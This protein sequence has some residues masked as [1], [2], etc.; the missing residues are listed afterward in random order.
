MNLWRFINPFVALL[1]RSPLHFLISSQLLVVSFKGIKSGKKYL[2]PVSYHQH[3][4]DYTA[5]TL[6]SNIWWKNLKQS[7]TTEIWLKG[8][9]VKVGIQL[10]FDNNQAVA[11]TL[12]NLV[13]NNAID[14]F[15]AKIKLNK[16]GTPVQED[17]AN[18]ASLHT[19]L[20]F[21]V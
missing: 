1:A 3:K 16:D 4:N 2:I 19:V 21:T 12:T 17:L 9:L 13:T 20:K 10:E 11:E 14:A 6:R 5:V 18:A 15:F 8:K 7:S